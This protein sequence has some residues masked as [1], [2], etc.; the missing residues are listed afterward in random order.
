VT[1]IDVVVQAMHA[2]R[3]LFDRL[4][5][6]FW[7]RVRVAESGC[8]EWI[9]GTNMYGYGAYRIDGKVKRTH[10]LTFELLVGPVPEDKELDHLCRVR[11]CC[12]PK[13]LEAVT[14]EENM[15]RGDW[16]GR[17]ARTHCRHGHPYEGNL[18]IQANGARG[19]VIC[20]ARWKRNDRARKARSK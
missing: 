20:R 12:N 1:E 6:G 5:A 7:A 19:C 4:P 11:R 17:L 10:R 15:R 3:P 13:H 14:H 18:F 16:S 2:L 8:W 9:G